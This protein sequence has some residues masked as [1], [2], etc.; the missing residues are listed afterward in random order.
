MLLSLRKCGCITRMMTVIL[1][2]S[3]P[4][5][6]SLSHIPYSL[7]CLVFPYKETITH[8]DNSKQYEGRREKGKTIFQ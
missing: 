6:L 8:T 4:L 1:I 7:E 3:R 2:F 5:S